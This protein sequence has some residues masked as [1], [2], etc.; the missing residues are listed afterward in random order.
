M[1]IRR[2]SALPLVLVLALAA[3]R[4]RETPPPRHPRASILKDI[5]AAAY[6]QLRDTSGTS[7]AEQWT[8]TTRLP[9]DTTAAFYRA[10]LPQ[11]GWQLMSDRSDRPAGTIDLYAR[12]GT[13]TL[14]VHVEKQAEETS[15]YTLIAAADTTVARA[16]P[17][18]RDSTR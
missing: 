12:M 17:A 8:Y 15:R 10:F 4:V 5:P 9:F 11:L 6:S 18:R 2:L 16:A 14:W 7:D 3:C 13:H 1:E